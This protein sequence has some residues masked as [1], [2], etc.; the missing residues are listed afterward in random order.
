[1]WT[2][3]PDRQWYCWISRSTVPTDFKCCDNIQRRLRIGADSFFFGVGVKLSAV[4]RRRSAQK[5]SN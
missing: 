5:I 3:S 4:R 1:V 2:P